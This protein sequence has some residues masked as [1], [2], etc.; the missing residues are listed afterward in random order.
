MKHLLFHHE[1][2]EGQYWYDEQTCVDDFLEHLDQEEIFNI[3]SFSYS[4]R[5]LIQ[6]GL[7]GDTNWFQEIYED[8]I[9][10]CISDDVFDGWY[11]DDEIKDFIIMDEEK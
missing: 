5:K 6:H 9:N 2:S 10:Y 3:I 7:D 8:A 11:T 1:Y 4:L